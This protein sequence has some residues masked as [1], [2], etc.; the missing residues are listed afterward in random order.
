MTLTQFLEILL[1]ILVSK[2]SSSQQLS[3]IMSCASIFLK[4]MFKEKVE[5]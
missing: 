3:K 5:N 2:T 4:K 1:G